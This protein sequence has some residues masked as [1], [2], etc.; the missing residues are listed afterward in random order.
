MHRI[1]RF[2]AKALCR[3]AALLALIPALIGALGFAAPARAHPLDMYF[4]SHEVH[5]T[6][7]GVEV[8]TTIRPGP[9]M[10]LSEWY[11]LDSDTDGEITPKEIT[12]WSAARMDAFSIALDGTGSPPLMLLS[13]GWPSSPESVQLG[14]ESFHFTA[15]AQW[16]TPVGY[17]AAH[18][19]ELHFL[20][21]EARSINWYHLY[22][23]DRIA[24]GI[25]EQENGL[26]SVDIHIVADSLPATSGLT[27]WDSGSPALGSTDAETPPA[28][29]TDT[30]STTAI[31]TGL[32][33][34]PDLGASFYL[35]AFAVTLIL[36]SIH[37]LTPGHG[38]ALAAAYLIGERGTVGHALALGAIV[39]A[40]HTGSVMI[41]GLITLALSQ[42][43][44]PAD[45]F[46]YLEL[47]SGLMIVALAAGLLLPR[48][49]G[50]RRVFRARKRAAS[51]PPEAP[52]AAAARRVAVKE[53]VDART[54]DGLL[55]GIRP[56]AAGPTRR[57]LIT[58]GVS[59]GLVPCPDAVAILL[60]A[61]AIN[62]ILLGLT[63][64]ATFSLGMAAVLILLG[65]AVVR[66]RR[67]LDRFDVISRAAPALPF[68]SAAVILGVGLIMTADVV[69]RYGLGRA[70]R[71]A[72][73][74]T[75]P[76]GPT[77]PPFDIARAGFYFLARGTDGKLQIHRQSPIGQAPQR[78]SNIPEGV[79]DFALSPD[80]ASIGFASAG[81]E[82]S[83]IWIL[84]TSG[85]E[86]QLAVDCGEAFCA[87][88]L[89]TPDGG[90]LTYERT[91]PD[92]VSAVPTLWSY[93]LAEGT[94]QTVFRDANIP[95]YTASW[96]PDGDW[97][98]YWSFPGSPTMEIY[99]LRSGDRDAIASQTGLAAV[100][101]P[102]GTALL[103]T[104]ILT[105]AVP[106]VSHLFRYDLEEKT[107]T[108][109]SR[110]P[111]IQD[112]SASWSPDGGWLA[113]VRRAGTDAGSSGTQIWLMR[114]D[115]TDAHPVTTAAN[116]FH[117]GLFWSPDGRYLLVQQ[118]GLEGESPSPEIRLLD[119][120]TGE[121]TLLVEDGIW[122][123][124]GP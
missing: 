102:D 111:G 119:V 18:R 71:T 41:F 123:R 66:G 23:E 92:T 101:S 68:I 29:P 93:S 32:I 113:V 7:E 1:I 85:G 36:G 67:W 33:R 81:E 49:R 100:W 22:G 35:F 94:A 42:F 112:Y 43:F 17:G 40:T 90:H 82:G 106:P 88:V 16:P 50:Y 5:L 59:G 87:N 53:A 44:I 65:L 95:G 89:W 105:A 28:D 91:E 73:V 78:I 37:A 46:P 2:P 60:I 120:E 21:E 97:L 13:V 79:S 48:W 25:P 64:V 84:S 98:S 38:K 86:E 117:F 51:P 47:I 62:R 31:L 61:V 10:A 69:N 30:R 80:G 58:L 107:L 26:L 15:R 108:D 9:L 11:A 75:A 122:P 6:P 70:D 14:E 124:W 83:R 27:Y 110:D 3:R 24:F 56:A 99:N 63:L 114:P 45:F 8:Q 74:P 19:L 104:D 12:D 115:G 55:P 20:Y 72:T 39:T 77:A 4:F 76:P 34:T 121:Y 54:Y 118:Q 57:T 52:P 103:L 109:L 96:S 116:A